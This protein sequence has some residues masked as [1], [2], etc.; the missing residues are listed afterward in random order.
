MASRNPSSSPSSNSGR[1]GRHCGSRVLLGP[2]FL[3]LLLGWLA[4]LRTTR[5][6]V[7]ADKSTTESD[8]RR[9][10]S[11]YPIKSVAYPIFRSTENDY[12][13]QQYHESYERQ[14]RQCDRLDCFCPLGRMQ[15][16][17]F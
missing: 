6:K 9:E 1:G 3:L 11:L 8:H 14:Q 10:D 13:R 15:R 7:V 5:T 4:L 17:L 2:L 12:E 16:G